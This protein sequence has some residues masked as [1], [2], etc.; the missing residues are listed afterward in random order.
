MRIEVLT[1]VFFLALQVHG[2][3]EGERWTTGEVDLGNNGDT[4]FYYLF[5]ARKVANRGKKLLIWFNGGPG[6]SSSTGLFT[7]N[8]PY[9][10]F[11]KSSKLSYNPYSWNTEYDIM[12]VDQPVGVGYSLVK[13]EQHY[14]VTEVCVSKNFYVFLVKFLE[15]DHPEYA[16]VPIYLTGESY[17]GHYIPAIMATV[18][19]ANNPLINLKGVAIGNG[20]MDRAL[21]ILVYPDY[22][23]QQGNITWF[24]YIFFKSMAIMCNIAIP[25]RIQV[26]EYFCMGTI[27]ILRNFSGLYNPYDIRRN[28]TDDILDDYTLDILNDKKVQEQ[29]GFKSFRK[30]SSICN[31]TIYEYMR[32][33]LCTSV[34][35]DMVYALNKGLEVFMFSGDKDYQCN[36]L[37]NELVANSLQW[38]HQNKYL[39]AEY[40]N[41]TF[42]GKVHARYRKHK[43]LAFMVVYNAGHMVP[44]DQGPFALE[45]LHLFIENKL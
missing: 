27:S 20:M 37:S 4:I 25:Y 21:Q 5:S 23:L 34:L 17:A 11:N 29:F 24:G 41:L 38:E 3:F 9:M 6:C 33:D 14:C 44:M 40:K 39:D 32:P 22:V 13:D 42:N 18:L 10:F 1:L 36:W 43:N 7:E 28:D 8:G 15:E 45:M 16:E 30:V 35:D 12:F 2:I 31:G 19:R 26:L